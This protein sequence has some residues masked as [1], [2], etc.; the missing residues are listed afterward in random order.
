MFSLLFKCET[1]KLFHLAAGKQIHL[2][3]LLHQFSADEYNINN[4]YLYMILEFIMDRNSQDVH[5]SEVI[6]QLTVLILEFF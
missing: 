4:I 1:L 3:Q 6:Y 2:G 5:L